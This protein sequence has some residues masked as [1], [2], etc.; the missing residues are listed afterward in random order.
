MRHPTPYMYVLHVRSLHTGSYIYIHVS[1]PQPANP[2]DTAALTSPPLTSKSKT[3][4]KWSFRHPSETKWFPF[5][6]S[7]DKDFG[8]SETKLFLRSRQGFPTS[9]SSFL[10]LATSKNLFSFC[11][12]LDYIKPLFISVL[13]YTFMIC[14]L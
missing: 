4:D 8:R 3:C 10:L 12:M 2:H 1:D 14:S 5:P 6:T 7:A 9:R 11:V 13:E